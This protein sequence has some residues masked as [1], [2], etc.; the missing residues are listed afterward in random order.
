MPIEGLVY[1]YLEKDRG[2]LVYNSEL[3]ERAMVSCPD[4]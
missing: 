1:C 4:S 2:S 3:L